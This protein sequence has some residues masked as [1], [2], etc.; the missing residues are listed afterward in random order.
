MDLK[1]AIID[2]GSVTTID[3]G[4]SDMDPHMAEDELKF[5]DYSKMSK[6]ANKYP[7]R[8]GGFG[9][10]GEEIFQSENDILISGDDPDGKPVP[11]SAPW[12]FSLFAQYFGVTTEDVLSRIT[13]SMMPLKAPT[14]ESYIERF[15][16]NNPDVYGPFWISVTLI[17]SIAIFSNLSSYLI[18]DEREQTW[19]NNWQIISKRI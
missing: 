19:H 6:E 14:G 12:G 3:M 9:Q 4:V 10:G 5:Q 2:I 1:P 7:S 13:W 16:R 8:V 17:F 18:T 15:I 11:P